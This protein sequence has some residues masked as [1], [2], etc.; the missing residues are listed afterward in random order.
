MFWRENDFLPFSVLGSR[1]GLYRD[2]G[3]FMLFLSPTSNLLISPSSSDSPHPSW[4]R[5]QAMEEEAGLGHTNY[6]PTLSEIGQSWERG[7]HEVIS[8]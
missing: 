1:R 8:Y 2:K 6:D 4:S 5:P 7:R 3:G